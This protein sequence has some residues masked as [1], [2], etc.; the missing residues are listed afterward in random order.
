MFRHLLAATDGSELAQKAARAAIDLAVTLKA[1]VTL[2]T[3]SKP[4]RVVSLDPLIASEA[5]ELEYLK[6]SARLARERLKPGEDYALSKGVKL[7]SVHVYE[8]HVWKA[9]I[10]EA[11]ANV[12]D[13]V[14]IASHGRKGTV[15]LLI[16]SETAKVLTH[17][18]LPVLVYR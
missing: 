6:D 13:L 16:G 1:A 3:V 17:S 2:V 8:E 15:A 4:W 14:F 11:R 5:N 18:T 12:C 9:I 7:R 10:D